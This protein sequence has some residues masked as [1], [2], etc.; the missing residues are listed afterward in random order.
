MS[1]ASLDSLRLIRLATRVQ[2]L[3]LMAALRALG[4]LR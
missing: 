1:Q 4:V 3:G 2:G